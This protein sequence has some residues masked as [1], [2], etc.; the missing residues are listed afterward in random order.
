MY[1]TAAES[2]GTIPYY[3]DNNIQ[4]SYCIIFADSMQKLLYCAICCP[5]CEQI[6]QLDNKSVLKDWWSVPKQH[7]E[8]DTLLY[9]LTIFITAHM[10]YGPTLKGI[11]HPKMKILSS[12]TH[13]QVVPNMYLFVL[14]NTKEDILKKVC[15]QAVLGHH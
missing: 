9:F 10:Y 15:N 5:V 7:H 1:C 3:I 13:S 2:A 4:T 14:L 8:G 12:F 6:T 11:V